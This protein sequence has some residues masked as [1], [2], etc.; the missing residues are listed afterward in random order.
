MLSGLF[1]YCAG[2]ETPAMSRTADD[3]TRA[4]SQPAAS[5]KLRGAGKL[6]GMSTIAEDQ[7]KQPAK[8]AEP[9]AQTNITV[10]TPTL[11]SPS[12]NAV[13]QPPA[14]G[15]AA[16]ETVAAQSYDRLTASQPV[17]AAMIHF[18][19]NSEKIQGD[20]YSILNE[21]A[22]ALQNSLPDAVLI[23]AGHTDAQGSAQYNLQ[24][25]QR[26]AQSVKDYL[27]RRG[28]AARRLIARGYGETYPMAANDTTDGR[29]LN[30]RSEFI[31][32]DNM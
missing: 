5:M 20:T 27:V 10:T 26:R 9:P 8:V 17:A 21:L 15:V 24:L 31:R 18:E 1:S 19:S 13:N 12:S 4:L 11:Q 30:R 2:A 7:P 6:R 32:V 25:S 22:T 28:I 29:A 23:I 14:S 16:A 3:F